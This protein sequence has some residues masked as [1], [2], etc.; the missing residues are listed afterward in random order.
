[1]AWQDCEMCR[2][3]GYV[4]RIVKREPFATSPHSNRTVTRDDDPPPR[5]EQWLCEACKG[6]ARI[7][8]E[9]KSR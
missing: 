1:M 2:G 7:Y 9:S 3:T 8:V 5:R 4:L 6:R